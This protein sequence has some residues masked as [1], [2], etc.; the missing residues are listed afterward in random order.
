MDGLKPQ[1]VLLFCGYESPCMDRREF[2]HSPSVPDRV[3]GDLAVD[4]LGVASCLG[5]LGDSRG[6][7]IQ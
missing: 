2:H 7:E 5:L 6:G 3:L 4:I 1:S